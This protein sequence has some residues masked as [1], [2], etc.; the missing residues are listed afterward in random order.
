MQQLYIYARMMHRL[1]VLVMVVLTLIMAITGSMMKY[2]LA[3][4]LIF[5]LDPVFARYIHNMISPFFSFALLGMAATGLYMYFYPMIRRNM[6]KKE[7]ST[8]PP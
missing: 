6:M 8:T 3:V 2:P 1:L 5:F 7:K 4:R